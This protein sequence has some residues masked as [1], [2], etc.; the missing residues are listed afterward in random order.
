[1]D[2][3]TTILATNASNH[4]ASSVDNDDSRMDTAV[5]IPATIQRL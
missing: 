2:T 4:I 5:T 3:A 1:M